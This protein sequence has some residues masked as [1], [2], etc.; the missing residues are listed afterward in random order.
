M[1]GLAPKPNLR[2]YSSTFAAPMRWAIWIVPMFD[3]MVRMPATVSWLGSCSASVN[4]GAAELEVRRGPGA[5]W[6]G[7]TMPF[8]S[9]ADTVITL[10][11]EPGSNTVVSAALF[12]EA[13]TVPVFGIVRPRWPSPGSHRSTGR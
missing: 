6:S 10:F 2:R 7:A 12:D 8:S 5:P 13:W 3:D 4:G 9:A 11:T 1:A